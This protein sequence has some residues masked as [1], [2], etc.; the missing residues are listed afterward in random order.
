[1]GVRYK[2]TYKIWEFVLYIGLGE[3]LYTKF[4]FYQYRDIFNH[5]LFTFFS[6]PLL[7]LFSIEDFHSTYT[8]CLALSHRTLRIC[9]IFY[10][11]FFS[12]LQNWVNSFHV[13]SKSL[14][15]LLFKICY[16][17]PLQKYHFCLFYFSIPKFLFLKI[18]ILL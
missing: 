14:V 3:S 13:F 9:S 4:F 5:S 15:L 11:I 6:C 2:I 16:S 8:V 10:I 7:T 18:S 1:M 17:V 12:V